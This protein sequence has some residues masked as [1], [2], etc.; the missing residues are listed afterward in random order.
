MVKEVKLHCLTRFFQSLRYM[1][2]VA[3]WRCV[4][5]RMVMTKSYNRGITDQSLFNNLPYIY[6]CSCYPS[7][8]YPYRL[9]QPEIIRHQQNISF[10]MVKRHHTRTYM[11]IYSL[12]AV[13]PDLF[14]TFFGKTSTKFYCSLQSYRLAITYSLHNLKLLNTAFA[15]ISQTA[16]HDI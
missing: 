12:C 15:Y 7:T 14:C 2:I 10:F 4:V 9:N 16:I 5:A 3:A 8:T 6:C 1:V 11:S 13:K